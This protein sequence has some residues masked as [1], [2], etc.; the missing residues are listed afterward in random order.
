MSD[1]T[2]V[3]VNGEPR[4]L[5]LQL[6]ERLGFDR[7]RKIRD[8][9]SRNIE[10]LKQINICPTV[11]QIHDGPG[12]PTKAYYLDQKQSIFLCMKAD[13]ANAFEVQL[14]IIDVFAAY[15]RGESGLSARPARSEEEV[16][17]TISGTWKTY[18][19]FLEQKTGQCYRAL[20]PTAASATPERTPATRKVKPRRAR[21]MTQVEHEKIRE[22]FN[23]G[24]SRLDISRAI[25]RDKRCI[26]RSLER[27]TSTGMEATD[28]AR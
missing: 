13:T 2:L 18:A 8:L 27:M 11:G 19:L 7:P 9:I 25:G 21:P 16:L 23:Q 12:R 22:L 20:P 24:M 3:P 6:A 10:K 15:L 4:I 17:V 26:D 1:L 28:D 5:D 14:E